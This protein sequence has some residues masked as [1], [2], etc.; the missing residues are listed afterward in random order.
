MIALDKENEAPR[1]CRTATATA[2]TRQ[3]GVRKKKQSGPRTTSGTARYLIPTGG[4]P[5]YQL[6]FVNARP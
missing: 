6:K 3:F 1:C 4:V 2:T 5:G